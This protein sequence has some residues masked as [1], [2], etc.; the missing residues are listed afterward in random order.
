MGDDLRALRQRRRWRQEDLARAAGFTRAVV[1]MIERGYAGRV[2]LD[3]IERVAGAL[4]AR[5]SCRFTWQGE[6][7]DRLR[8]RDH[9]A[10]V[11]RV[12][13]HLAAAGWGTATEVSFN[14]YGERGSIDVLGYHHVTRTLLVVEVKA[15]IGDVQATLTAL[16]R[17]TRLAPAI[18]R[19]RSW[20]AASVSTMLVVRDDR[21]ARR[22]VGEH[23]ATF[24]SAYP[25]RSRE[26][27]RWVAAPSPRRPFRAI[28][29]LSGESDGRAR[30][31]RIVRLTA[32]ERGRRPTSRHP[33]P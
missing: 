6:S 11:E 12:V 22:R 31:R 18:A 27:R 32:A 14:V 4:D 10:L 7:L 29:F 13:R 3:T 30:P 25:A 2:T 24:R 16:D 23:E 19:E 8:D 26:A 15:S 1:S 33:R 17:K 5:V 9:A 28:W 20:A 21:T